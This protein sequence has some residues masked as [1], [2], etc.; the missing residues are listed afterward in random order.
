MGARVYD[1]YTGTFT[2]PDP[3]Q[4]GSA[5]AYGYTAGDPVNGSDLTGDFLCQTPGSVNLITAV[6][7]LFGASC[8]S[9]QSTFNVVKTVATPIVFAAAT[10]GAGE[11]FAPVGDLGNAG[12]EDAGIGIDEN[13]TGHIFRSAS[14][15]MAEDTAKNRAVLTDT[16]NNS[17]N[18]VGT[19]GY[20]ND[21]YAST[22]EDGSQAW[23]RVRGGKITNG[24]VNQ[25]PWRTFGPHGLRP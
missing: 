8:P 18:H 15:H 1:P 4:G 12:A 3:I 13:A 5:N 2:Q 21:W 20:G 17:A 19:D 14:G 16:A 11:I 10:G 6:A 7:G 24:G 22:R 25:T 9:A 23:A